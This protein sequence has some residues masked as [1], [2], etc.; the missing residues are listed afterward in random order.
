ML[1]NKSKTIMK[2]LVLTI[3]FLIT[4]FNLSTA[5]NNDPNNKKDKNLF[6]E[7][8]QFGG[9]LNI[10]INNNVTSIGI[11]P[12]AIYNFDERFS[13]G[14]GASY[15]YS[16]FKNINDGLNIFGGSVLALYNP[17]QGLQL[18]S[19]FEKSFLN[20]SGISRDVDALYLGLAYTLGRNIAVGMRYDVLYDSSESFYASAFTPIA[21]FYF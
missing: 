20:Q 4:F 13:A 9:G 1:A 18:S 6:W 2:K 21:R 8:V 11:S 5:Q 12:S 19:E 17:A 14:V 7:K 10:G 15:L 3:T 16:K